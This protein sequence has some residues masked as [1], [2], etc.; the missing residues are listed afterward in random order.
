MRT[1]YTTLNWVEQAQQRANRLLAETR[2]HRIQLSRT[3][4][5][6]EIANTRLRRVERE[7]TI[8]KREAEEARRLKEQF[9]ANVSHELRTPLNLI[10]GFSEMMYL[11]P[12]VYGPVNWTPPLRRDT[13]QIYRNGRH[14]LEMIDD[15]LALSQFEIAGFTLNKEATDVPT[16]L[17]GALDIARDLFRTRPVSLELH[18]ASDLPRVEIDQ[19]RIR[20][21]LL[22]LLNNA[23]RFTTEGT[24]QVIATKSDR[25]VMIQVVDTGPGIPEEHREHIFREFYQVD[26]SLR[27]SHSGAGLGLAICKQFVQAHDGRI[28]VESELGKGSTFTFTL[29]IPEQHVP[30]SH[31]SLVPSLEPLAMHIDPVVMVV[32]PDP[33]VA[34]IVRHYV[35]GYEIRHVSKST[36]LP[37]LVRIYHPRAVIYNRSSLD[38]SELLPL[39]GG[40]PIIAC[41]LPSRAWIMDAWDVDGCLSKP[42]SAEQL[43]KE[44][45]RLETQAGRRFDSVLVVDDDRGFCQLITRF[46][47]SSG[48]A[49]QIRRAYDGEEALRI[50]HNEPPDLLLLDLLMPS[51]DGFSVLAEIRQMPLSGMAVLLLTATDLR[52]SLGT[53]QDASIVVRRL[54][55]MRPGETLRWIAAMLAAVE[56]RYTDEGEIAAYQGTTLN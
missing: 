46:L 39:P 5:S 25:E 35:Q 19:T 43:L 31:L 17:Q 33:V 48:R 29:P 36:D 16:L 13:Y 10:L 47:E 3:L 56:P 54:G 21:V 18:L 28:W 32:D 51:K 41:T 40:L 14:L 4:Q 11:S 37:S 27:R 30:L 53:N 26:L 8:A 1:L 6:A 20:Q 7:L 2:T 44:I 23:L 52:E 22:N 34:S 24:V 9:A 55:G 38:P 15:I 12:E 42:L 49:V 50:L 45:A